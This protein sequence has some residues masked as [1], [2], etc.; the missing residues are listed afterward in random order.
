MTRILFTAL[1]TA[2]VAAL[3]SNFIVPLVRELAFAL[4]AIDRPGGRKTHR[5]EIARLGGIGV[6]AGLILG[7]G[8]VA[9]AEWT[10]WGAPL[11][12]RDLVTLSLGVVLVFLVGLVDDVGGVSVWKKLSVEVVAAS[13]LVTVGTAWRFE[14]L[15]LPGGAVL[16]LGLWSAP[17]TMLWIVGVTN[18]INLIDGLDGLASGV[19]AIIA[20]SF[21]VFALLVDSP[22]NVVL[23]AAIL[24]ACLGFLPHNRE[25]ARIFLGDAGSLALG[26]LLAACS[27]QTGLKSPSAVAIMVPLLALGVPVIDTLLVMML[28]FLERPKGTVFRRFLRVFHADRNHLHHLLESAVTNRRGAV[29]WVYA[30]V[31]LSTLMALAVALTKSPSLGVVLVVVEVVAIALVRDLGMARRAGLLSRRQRRRIEA[32]ARAAD[33]LARIERIDFERRRSGGQFP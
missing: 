13:L 12:R 14:I 20:G 26:F 10:E 3:V 2:G 1:L 15:G 33:E 32:A 25:P 11:G 21:M 19:V 30:L 24:G 6:L 4:R 17:L 22:F 16:D 31:L 8:S 9:V 7:G 5:E 29:R 27:V 28:R 23:A 18:A